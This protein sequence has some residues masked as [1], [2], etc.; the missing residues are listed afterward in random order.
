MILRLKPLS[1]CCGN[2]LFTKKN[3]A[4][5]TKCGYPVCIECGGSQ[6]YKDGEC[7]DCTGKWRSKI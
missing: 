7:G 1:D 6:V 5:C 2:Q 4:W 3:R